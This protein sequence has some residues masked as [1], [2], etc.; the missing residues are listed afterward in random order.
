VIVGYGFWILLLSDVVMFSAFF[1][2][3]AVLSGE[4]AGGPSGKDV[5]HLHIGFCVDLAHLVASSIGSTGC[6]RDVRG[7]CLA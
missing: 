4:T 7:L 2:V 6:V 5:F 3:Y 1:A